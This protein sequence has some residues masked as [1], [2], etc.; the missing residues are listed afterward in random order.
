MNSRDFEAKIET[1]RKTRRYLLSL[2]EGLSLEALN[3]IPEGFSNNIL[4]N[5]GH[6]VAAQQGICYLRAGRDMRV[7]QSYFE[8]YRP[9]SVPREPATEQTRARINALLFSTLDELE[10]DINAGVFEHYEPLQTRYGVAISHIGD[11]V[12]FLLFHEGLHSGYIMAL[13]RAV[14]GKA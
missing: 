8:A 10:A 2:V 4:W 3:A 5:L 1:V 13:K 6:L 12:S 9:G 14:A 7:D 11:A